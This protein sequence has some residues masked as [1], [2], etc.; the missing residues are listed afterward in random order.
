M[1]TGDADHGFLLAEVGRIL[2]QTA[3]AERH[4]QNAWTSPLLDAQALKS[5]PMIMTLP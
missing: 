1:K 2:S 3:P 5:V 4:P